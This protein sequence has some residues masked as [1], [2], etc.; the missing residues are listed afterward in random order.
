M[1]VRRR[2][3]DEVKPDPAL[4]KD[5]VFS[6]KPPPPEALPQITEPAAIPEA[7]EIASPVKEIALPEAKSQASA[8][9]ARAPLTTRIRADYATA[10]K[11]PP[12]NASSSGVSPNTVQDILEAALEP[13][14][15][16]NGYLP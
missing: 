10:L 2:L 13:W 14:L 7:K 4:E 5:F 3:V 15:R 16:S 6:R 1:A 12:W 9:I 11:R 8:P